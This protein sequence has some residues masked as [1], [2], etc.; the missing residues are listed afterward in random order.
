MNWF[1]IAASTGTIT[2]VVLA[3]SF[4]PFL[5]YFMLTWQAHMRAGAVKL[6]DPEDRTNAYVTISRIAHMLRSFI[7]GNLVIGLIIGI[8]SAAAFAALHIPYFYFIGLISGYL[9]LVPYLGVI[10]AV[11]PPA[12]AGM[13]VLGLKGFLMVGVIVL[14]AHLIA[15]NVLYPKMLG[16]RLQL[17]PLVVTV[18]LLAWGFIW[19]A[20]GLLLAIPVTA[21]LKIICDHVEGWQPIG[22]LMGEGK[23]EA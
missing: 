6:F 12:A 7:V 2:E 20:L 19:G 18:A 11:I 17:N 9:S 22:E 23:E 15:M 8:I 14:G 1:G 4:I 3:I 13:G 16:S 10:I 21:A 5:S